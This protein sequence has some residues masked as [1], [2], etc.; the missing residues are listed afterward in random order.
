MKRKLFL[1]L[2]IVFIFFVL[3]CKYSNI[4]LNTG[5]FQGKIDGYNLSG[6]GTI[7]EINDNSVLIK[8]DGFYALKKT[9]VTE[10]VT[11]LTVNLKEGEG[12]WLAYRCASNNYNNHPAILLNYSTK[13]LT[14]EEKGKNIINLDKYKARI[15]EPVRIVFLNDC[16]R[17]D[18]LLDCDTVYT[19]YTDIPNTEYL[20]VK[21]L[22]KSKVL[23]TGIS[24]DE[25]EEEEENK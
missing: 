12:V 2:P 3:A 15:N 22:P 5:K 6:Y 16:K 9:G 10:L 4:D 23:L 13:G 7:D 25:R 18:V 14:I 1:V 17:Y 21:T 19:G 11:D 24:L 8:E 20:L